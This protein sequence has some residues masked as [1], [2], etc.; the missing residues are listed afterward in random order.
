MRAA[1]GGS[2]SLRM[3]SR[4][5]R[6]EPEGGALAAWAWPGRGGGTGGHLGFPGQGGVGEEVVGWGQE[7]GGGEREGEEAA[8]G[9]GGDCLPARLGCGSGSR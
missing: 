1:A 7:G 8:A 9:Q 4:P 2:T 6:S 5:S 3:L